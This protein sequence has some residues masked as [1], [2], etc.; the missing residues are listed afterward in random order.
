MKKIMAGA[1]LAL[2]AIALLVAQRK[3]EQAAISGPEYTGDDKLVLPANYREWTFLSSGLGMN[4]GPVAEA[5]RDR[6]PV[7]DNVF[8]NPDAYR[9]FLKNGAWPEKTM[10]ILEIR[11][12]VSKGSINT[13][14]HYQGDV[15]AVEA[16]VKDTARLGGWGF[17]AIGKAASGKQIP[18]TAAC[19]SCHLQKGAV[20]NTFVQF[21]PTLLTVAKEKG[22]LNPAYVSAEK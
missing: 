11:A 6:P 16:E 5:N 3:P 10:F 22:T 21:Y 20:D 13:G 2:F 12:S 8:V 4:Y 1:V 17:F 7:F 18:K 15:M 14:G 19:Y 9:S